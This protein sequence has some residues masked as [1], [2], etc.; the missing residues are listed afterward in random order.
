M[1]NDG[2]VSL[3]TKGSMKV[4]DMRRANED[5]H[6]IQYELIKVPLKF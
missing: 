3:C 4:G 6:L 5:P 1:Q 2:N